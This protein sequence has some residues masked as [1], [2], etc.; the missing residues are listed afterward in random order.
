MTT[1]QHLDLARVAE[2]V[3]FDERGAGN[4]QLLPAGPLR[5]AVPD[6]LTAHQ[7]LVY[8]NGSAS[9]PLP[10]YLAERSL[11]AALPLSAWWARDNA[12]GVAVSSLPDRHW[13]AVAGLAAPEK[14]FRML[15]DAGLSITRCPQPDHAP[16]DRLP[17]PAATT[18][19]VT[20][21]KD[22]VKLPTGAVGDAQVWV[23][24]LDL[25][26]PAALITQIITLLK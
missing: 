17:W 12:Q 15:R 25:K 24:G 10:G 16:Y 1:L 13:L 23:V 26:L 18:H 14:F 2:V 9:T 3:V 5:G 6:S 19:V 22:A 4:G 11:G 7:L 21:E 8:S 20:T